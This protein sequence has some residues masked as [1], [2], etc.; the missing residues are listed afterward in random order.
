VHADIEAMSRLVISYADRVGAGRSAEARYRA[1][2][3]AWRART[4]LVWLV[5]ML[6]VPLLML[7][8]AWIWPADTS[9]ALG[10]AVGATVMFALSIT[11]MAPQHIDSWRQGAEGEKRTAKALRGLARR[12]WMVMH[13]LPDGYGNRDHVVVAPSGEIFLLDTKAPGGRVTVEHG[14][15]RVRWLEDPDDGY[16]KDLTPK[17]KGAAAGLADELAQALPRRP[18]VT[19]VVVIWGRWDGAPH[20][21]SGVAWVPGKALAER[22]SANVDAPDHAR[23]AR[24]VEALRARIAE[25]PPA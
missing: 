19:P 25:A 23:Q 8:V 4:R 3:R 22:L 21:H 2:Y 6:P 14:V 10:T 7:A 9:L 17:M 1:L 16:E 13:D 12:G 20:M 15:L 18:W 5:A 24:V 11:L